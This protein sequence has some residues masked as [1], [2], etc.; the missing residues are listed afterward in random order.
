MKLR[1]IKPSRSGNGNRRGVLV[2][3]SIWLVLFACIIAGTLFSVIRIS[4]LRS[5]ARHCVECAALAAGYQFLSDDMLR[6]NQESFETDGR[7]ARAEGAAVDIAADFCRATPLQP[8]TADCV[9]MAWPDLQEQLSALTCPVP[10]NISVSM[11]RP[12]QSRAIPL[13][14][15]GLTTS[16]VSGLNVR[17]TVSLERTPK[18]FSPGPRNNVPV[19]PFAILDQ[20]Q[21][22]ANSSASQDKQSTPGHWTKSIESGQGNDQY[23]WNDERHVFVEGRDGLPE[24]TVVLTSSVSLDAPDALIPLQFAAGD[25]DALDPAIW[26][27]DGLSEQDLQTLGKASLE[28]P[29]EH[30]V[31]PLSTKQLTRAVAALRE[32]AGDPFVV[33]L[34]STLSGNTDTESEAHASI[35]LVRP[36]AARIVR[37]DD[38]EKDVVRVILQPC[39]ISTST[40]LMTPGPQTPVNR[41]VYSV[42]IL[43]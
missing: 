31:M 21:S 5:Q 39:V 2:A 40:A 13:F 16:P 22:T 29:S 24:I 1:P 36:V 41:Y 18:G 37:V 12:G 23:T 43:H 30:P 6:A 38:S 9:E 14:F 33:C 7:I 42:R 17:C 34:G 19:L 3:W 11:A 15:Q 28:F 26:I 20:A 10:E 8:I 27:R 32:N 25:R 4:A 35:R